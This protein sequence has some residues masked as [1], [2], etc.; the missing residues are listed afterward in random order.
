MSREEGANN[1]PNKDDTRGQST[2]IIYAQTNQRFVWK[3]AFSSI[4]V[5]E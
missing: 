4:T 2:V 3:T 5:Y 1:A